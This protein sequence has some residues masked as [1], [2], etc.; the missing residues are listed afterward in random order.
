MKQLKWDVPFADHH[1]WKLDIA[2]VKKDEYGWSVE[3]TTLGDNPE[4]WHV[5]FTDVTGVKYSNESFFDW[6]AWST[7]LEASHQAA[8]YI[9]EDGDWR[10]EFWSGRDTAHFPSTH[11]A[12]ATT[13]CLLEV[14][15]Q[16][17]VIRDPADVAADRAYYGS[18]TRSQKP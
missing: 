2:S 18:L 14:L 12:I 6:E 15:A 10:G 5:Y 9:V 3:V 8:A 16:H 11:Y 4:S 13:G 7:R 17:G 1:P